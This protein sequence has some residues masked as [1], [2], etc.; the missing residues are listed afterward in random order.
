[1]RSRSMSSDPIAT[2]PY[3]MRTEAGRVA[4]AAR[5]AA[6]WARDFD[7][8]IEA[9]QEELHALISLRQVAVA[10]PAELLSRGWDPLLMGPDKIEWRHPSE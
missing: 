5:Q 6:I 1:M 4:L 10:L 2:A 9:C 7:A 3:A 8:A